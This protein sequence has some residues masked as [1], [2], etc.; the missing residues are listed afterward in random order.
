[1]N[2]R[3]GDYIHVLTRVRSHLPLEGGYWN[4][5]SDK[6]LP[7]VQY[8]NPWYGHMSTDITTKITIKKGH[9]HLHWHFERAQSL[10]LLPPAPPRPGPTIFAPHKVV[11]RGRPRQDGSTRRDPSLHEVVAPSQPRQRPGR[12]SGETSQVRSLI[13]Y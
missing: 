13:N 1:M 6:S 2:E 5:G 3:E 12:I 7:V 8:T 9:F 11:T 10:T 4:H